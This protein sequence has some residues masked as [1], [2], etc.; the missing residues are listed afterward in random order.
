MEKHNIIIYS[1]PTCPNCAKTKKY[2]NDN[3][4]EFENIDVSQNPDAIAKMIE[5]SGQMGVPVIDIDGQFIVGFQPGLFKKILGLGSA[6]DLDLLI[7]NGAVV[8]DVRTS[9]EYEQGHMKDSLN[10]PLDQLEDHLLE[11]NKN[12]PIIVCCESGSRSGVAKQILEANGFGD[13]YNG[14][15]C[16]NLKESVGGGSC[17]AE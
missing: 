17:P 6:T 11:L 15:N 4:V 14:G 16:N 8:V 1:T 9:A 3:N 7:A 10:I 13:V 2:F 12:K 5:K